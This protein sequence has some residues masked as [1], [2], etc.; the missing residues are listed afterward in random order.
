[1]PKKVLSAIRDECGTM[2]KNYDGYVLPWMIPDLNPHMSPPVSVTA[3][4]NIGASAEAWTEYRGIFV[5]DASALPSGVTISAAQIEA[6]ITAFGN[7]D[8]G[9][10][11]LISHACGFDID[12]GYD[13]C[14]GNTNGSQQHNLGSELSVDGRVVLGVSSMASVLLEDGKIKLRLHPNFD[15]DPPAWS[16]YGI[17]LLADTAKLRMSYYTTCDNG[18]Q[19]LCVLY[20]ILQE[21][22]GD[23][24]SLDGFAT[25]WLQGRDFWQEQAKVVFVRTG[26]ERRPEQSGEK[27]GVDREFTVAVGVKQLGDRAEEAAKGALRAAGIVRSILMDERRDLDGYGSVVS[28]EGPGKPEQK[29]VSG[30]QDEPLH[31]VCEIRGRVAFPSL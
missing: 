13:Y 25:A 20:E 3:Q 30:T 16:Q 21:Y 26:D 6:T 14:W 7:A 15:A 9:D 4:R 8:P 22:A 11:K 18:D 29:K 1:V 19:L 17:T 28:L 31:W 10:Y 23:G 12:E 5:F 27:Q 2:A 24:C